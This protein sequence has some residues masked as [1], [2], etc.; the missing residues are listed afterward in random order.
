MAED[1]LQVPP[2]TPAAPSQVPMP[3]HPPSSTTVEEAA[4]DAA[5]MIAAAA[6]TWQS[7]GNDEG[8]GNDARA[9]T[10]KD[11]MEEDDNCSGCARGGRALGVHRGRRVTASAALHSDGTDADGADVD[12]DCVADRG[13]HEEDSGGSTRRG[14][15]TSSG[16]RPPVAPHH[17]R[18]G[19]R[20]RSS[21]L[22]AAHAATLSSDEE[23]ETKV[24]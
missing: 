14:R 5:A 2:R 1:H 9:R 22:M 11:L 7:D 8:L 6:A 4:T 20:A 3:R 23:D 18:I 12:G 16:R 21:A 19:L 13:A 24:A 10:D 17:V 15:V